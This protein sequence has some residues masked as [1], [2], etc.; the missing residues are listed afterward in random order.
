MSQDIVIT[1]FVRTPIGKFGGAFRN[2]K[3]PYLAA[4][5]IKALIRRTGIDVKLV[6]E[7]VFGSTLQGNMGQNLSRFAALLAGLPIEVSAF[8]VNRVC[9]S[10]MQA[11]IELLEPLRLVM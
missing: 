4:E 1:G 6:D 10:G 8:T 3:T 5:T 2:V 7:V 11:I 9:S